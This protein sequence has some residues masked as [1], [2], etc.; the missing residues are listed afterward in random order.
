MNRT[1]SLPEVW[2]AVPGDPETLTGGYI[3]A[4]RLS[5]ALEARGWRVHRMALPAG[6]PDPSPADLAETHRALSTLPPR[7]ILLVDGLAFG[8]FT[9]AVFAGMDLDM[10]ALVHHPLALE[11]GLAG[12]RAQALAASERAA[13][14]TARAVIATSRHTAQVLA[15][16]YGVPAARLFVA[17]PGTDPRSRALGNPRKPR[18]LTVAT[19]TPRKGHDI[20]VAALARLADLPWTSTIAG[21]LTRA[22]DTVALL[23]QQIARSGVADRIALTG[24]ISAEALNTLYTGADIFVLPS[25]YE[26]YGMVFAEALAHGLPVAGCAAGAVVDTVPADAAVL[27]PAGDAAALASALRDLLCDSAARNRMAEAA[28]MAGQRLPRWEATA[29]IVADVLQVRS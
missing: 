3:Y 26:G 6:F 28:W 17:S 12:E 22:P 25:R 21:S 20:L 15:A 27:V 13:L 7:S 2:F 5:Q 16:D 29:A 9:P 19:V 4:K 24:E 10:V 23:R 8:A 18:L 11:T 1:S 14:G